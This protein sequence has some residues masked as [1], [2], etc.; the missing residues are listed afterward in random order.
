MRII[1]TFDPTKQKKT[2]KKLL[3]GAIFVLGSILS[4]NA[5]TT[6]LA[7]PFGTGSIPGGWA[8][9]VPA[10][11]ADNWKFSN[12]FGSNM[13][14]YVATQGFCTFVDDWDNNPS[15][16]TP[17]W[18]TLKGPSM[19]C[20][21]Y[22]KVW[23]S[24]NYMF[25]QDDGNETGTL[26]ISTNGGVTWTTAI[27]FPNTGGGWAN[28]AIYDISSFAASKPNVM[29]A[30]TYYDGF[31]TTTNGY[32]AVGMALQD[33]TIYSPA[34][35]NV[36]VA[37]QNLPPLM[38]V[39]QA[40]TFSGTAD[41]LGGTTVTSMQMNYSAN[42]G[43][44][45]SQTVSTSGFNS[46]TATNWSMNTSPFTPAAAG[47]YK[48]K[49]WAN[50]LN[51][52]DTN[53]NTDTLVAT[54]WA[55]DSVKP[56]ISVLEEFTGQSCVYCML[57]APNCDSVYDNNA[58]NTSMVRY[59]VP[60]PARDFMYVETTTWVN[61]RESYY[62]VNAAP[63]AWLDGASMNPSAYGNPPV[64][65][66]Y[67]STTVQ[68]DN[69]IGSP[70]KIDITNSKF[71]AATDSFLVTANITSYATFAAGLTAQV[72]LTI[73]SITYKQD[74][75]MDDPQISFAPP[76]GTGASGYSYT[77]CPDYFY[78]YVLKF[79]HVV[80][81]MLPSSNGTS[82]G[83]FTPGQTQTINLKWK[84]NHQWA[85]YDK[86]AAR[87]SDF[88]DS[89]STGQFV[90]FVQTN[91]AIAAD[92]IPA[93]YI[94]QSAH[95]PITGITTAGMKEISTGVYFEM[96]P[97]PT[98]GSTNLAFNL[99]KEQNV[100]VELFNML[101]E[102]I[103]TVN[104]GN[105]SAGSHTIM[106]NGSSLKNGVYFVKFNCDNATTTQKLIIQR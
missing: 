100:N 22:T 82:L 64:N 76:V 67:S 97:N 104:E 17:N 16:T 20:S 52:S 13:G 48:V 89:S 41:N 54:F 38:Q 29:V 80:E 65:Q 79:T 10:I 93:Q 77:N 90:V 7:Q 43:P 42:G 94:F 78:D 18:D 23:I 32:V 33:V 58:N 36:Q 53:V 61:P 51:S 101:G 34:D 8:E 14:S 1:N 71:D 84:K 75:S 98:N 73:D 55:V 5:Q 57:A 68:A 105:M 24:L 2:M 19:N 26:A 37:T 81:A 25:W 28:G 74:L 45:V 44:V 88:Y 102:K 30:F 31:A 11:T 66:R 62:A 35:Y 103:S 60:I 27:S 49:Y 86:G 95:A 99:D 9:N 83:A 87:D 15:Q 6:I 21:A 3:L 47:T 92:G 4:M 59:H 56:R 106:I 40:Y 50:P 12:A 85:A 96:Y 63:E 72:A 69:A 46:L 70:I 91:S 39:G